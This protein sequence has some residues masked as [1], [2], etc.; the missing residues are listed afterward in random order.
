MS[1]P[2]VITLSPETVAL[3]RSTPRWPAQMREAVRRT[4][5]L[6]NELTVGH[7]QSER[8]SGTGPFAVSEHKLGV[9]TNR[10][11]SSV[12]PSRATV[13][14]DQISSAIGTNVRYGGAHEFGFS[15]PVTVR[16]H[17]RKNPRADLIAFRGTTAPRQSFGAALASP[18]GR[19]RKGVVQV[20]SAVVTVRE[21]TAQ[22]VVPARAPMRHGIEDRAPA[23]GAALSTAIVA[24]LRPLPGAPTV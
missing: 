2:V 9:V 19:L 13:D 21:H 10:L 17:T 12:R 3:L 4:V 22:R 5:D 8:M 15:G 23:Y 11:R 1:D 6:Q 24:A 7:I 16:A 14:G 18:S 20:A